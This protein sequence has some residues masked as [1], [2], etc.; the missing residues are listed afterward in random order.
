MNFTY[1]VNNKNKESL[2][3]KNHALSTWL[4][5]HCP[6]SFMIFPLLSQSPPPRPVQVVSSTVIAYRH[7]PPGRVLEPLLWFVTRR[8]F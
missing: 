1:I 8:D 5:K 4:G 6:F 3:C 7:C 2:L